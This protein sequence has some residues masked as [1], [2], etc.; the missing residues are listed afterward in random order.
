MINKKWTKGQV[1]TEIRRILKHED[2]LD[3]FDTIVNSKLPSLDSCSLMDIIS[4][5]HTD[6]AVAHMYKMYDT[7]FDKSLFLIIAGSRHIRVSDG[8]IRELLETFNLKPDFIVEG[9]APGIDLCAKD[10][11]VRTGIPHLEFNANWN[12]Y[13]K[14]AGPV[15][16]KLMAKTGDSLLLIWN[17]ESRGSK[18]MKKQMLDLGK[19]IHER[20]I[21]D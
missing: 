3:N 15:R 17:G 14:A 9:G 13:G 12:S 7:H 8:Y 16:N 20:I 11:A 1:I 4:D 10:F 6:E 2:L 21:K 18:N 19:P 5:G